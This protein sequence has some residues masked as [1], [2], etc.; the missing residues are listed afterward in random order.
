MRRI[1]PPIEAVVFDFGNVLARFDHHKACRGLAPY[2]ALDAAEVYRR[3]F[4]EGL[5]RS[6]DEG[7]LTSRE[8]WRVVSDAIGARSLGYED[9]ARIWCDIFEPLPAVEPIVKA[10]VAAHPCLMLSNTNELH[11]STIRTFPVVRLFEDV[12]LSFELGLRKPD[13]LVFAAA[14]NRLNTPASAVLFIDD[15]ETNVGAAAAAGLR[16]SR[17]DVSKQQTA[18]L[19]ALLKSWGVLK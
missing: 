7:K 15:L 1:E 5:E 8:F 18:A 14:C 6:Y 2:A 11:W 3:I 13:P 4:A 9:F 19:T 10:A 12:L 17:F 16:A